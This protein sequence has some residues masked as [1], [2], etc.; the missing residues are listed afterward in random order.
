MWK[1]FQFIDLVHAQ[2]FAPVTQVRSTIELSDIILRVINWTFTIGGGLAVIYIIY[3]GFI[4]LTAGSDENKT[5]EA[6]NS[7]TSAII[8]LVIIALSF[9]IVNWLAVA[10]DFARPVRF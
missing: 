7:I 10:L 3:G 5:G 6:R 2:I 9:T 4:Y 8:G 1:F